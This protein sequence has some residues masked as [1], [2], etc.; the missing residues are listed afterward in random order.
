ME[1]KI[2]LI[3]NVVLGE[4]IVCAPNIK[5]AKS[6]AMNVFNSL[7]KKEANLMIAERMC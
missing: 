2:K 1:Y 5:K 3:K 6:E 4:I 7:D